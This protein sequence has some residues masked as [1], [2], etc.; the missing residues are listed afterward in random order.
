MSEKLGWV[1]LHRSIQTHWLYEEDRKFSKFEAWIDLILIA[2]HKDGKVMHDGQLIDVKRGQKLTSL[3]KL[4]KQ[5]NWSITKVDKFLNILHEDEMIVLKKDTQKTL[6]TIVNYDIY[7]NEDLEKRQRCDTEK[8]QKENK[9]ESKKKQKETNNNVNNDNN[10]NNVVVVSEDEFKEIYNMYQSNIQL[11]PPPTTT[12]RLQDDFDYFGK[13][14]MAFAIE[15]S[16]LGNNHDYRFIDYLLKEWR[17]NQLTTIEAVKQ[18]E[19]KKRSKAKPNERYNNS[20]YYTNKYPDRPD[21]SFS[22]LTLKINKLGLDGLTEEEQKALE[23][24]Y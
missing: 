2:N 15:K 8:K 20:Q 17:K 11:N 1:S 14:I 6:I 24:Y 3:R 5:W 10:V 22:T 16:A 4:G 23:S 13:D 21:L 12:Q 19:D 18:F 9:K 7:Q